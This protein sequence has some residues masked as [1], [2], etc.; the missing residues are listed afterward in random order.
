[1]QDRLILLCIGVSFFLVFELSFSSGGW[2]VYYQG[3]T[4]M[5]AAVPICR[6][7]GFPVAGTPLLLGRPGRGNHTAIGPAVQHGLG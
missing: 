2:Y 4:L 5:V 7:P 6:E 1:M 3:L